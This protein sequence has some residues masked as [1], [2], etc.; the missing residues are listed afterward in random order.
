MS[1]FDVCPGCR[2][3]KGA[4]HVV[5]CDLEQCPACGDELEACACP[6]Q[7][8]GR[9]AFGGEFPGTSAARHFGWFVRYTDHGW[10]RCAETD[11]GAIEDLHRVHAEACWIP[12]RQDW[13]RH[14]H[15]A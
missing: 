11:D 6:G 15:P 7:P 4:L 5:G 8:A 14:P 2:T 12:E 10:E 9:V 3:S 1:R 13:V